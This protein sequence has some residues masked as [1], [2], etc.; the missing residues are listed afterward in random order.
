VL[1][2]E[3]GHFG[4]ER[5]HCMVLPMSGLWAIPLS[6]SPTTAASSSTA[7]YSTTTAEGPGHEMHKDGVAE[8]RRMQRDGMSRRPARWLGTRG[9]A[10]AISEE[11]VASTGY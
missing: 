7:A 1:L 3:Q 8:G 4:P 5:V 2:Q 9:N 6:G 10:M 11:E